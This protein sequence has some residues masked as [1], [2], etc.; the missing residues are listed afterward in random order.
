MEFLQN[1][2]MYWGETLKF[3]TL[4]RFHY[5]PWDFLKHEN[6]MWSPTVDQAK[7]PVY[8]LSFVWFPLLFKVH[9]KNPN[10]MRHKHSKKCNFHF[11]WEYVPHRR[12]Q[13]LHR[14]PSLMVTSLSL[15]GV[16]GNWTWLFSVNKIIYWLDECL[17]YVSCECPSEQVEFKSKIKYI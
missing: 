4:A 13:S 9:I 10:L 12:W 7:L 8:C 16:R 17:R 14:L 15:Y 3:A 6:N 11:I 1:K 5:R 2:G